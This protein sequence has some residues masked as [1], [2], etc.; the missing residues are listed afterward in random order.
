MS[1]NDISWQNFV[2]NVIWLRKSNKL[3]KVEMAK[4]MRIDVTL[5]E[6][7]EK[8]NGGNILDAD[9]FYGIYNYFSVRPDDL[10]CKRLG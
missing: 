1:A 2:H 8:G 4:I 6:E 9:V 7:V 3:S 5:L 10:V